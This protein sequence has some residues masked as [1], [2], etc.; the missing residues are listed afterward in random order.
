MANDILMNDVPASPLTPTTPAQF[1]DVN[2]PSM[3]NLRQF[4][5]F[6]VVNTSPGQTTMHLPEM[7]QVTLDMIDI[8]L[9]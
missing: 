9:D 3:V 1:S 2:L 4:P 6:T 8:M 7:V 5:Q